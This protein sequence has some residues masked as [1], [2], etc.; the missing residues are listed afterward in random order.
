MSENALVVGKSDVQ[1][2]WMHE[3]MRMVRTRPILG[4]AN[5]LRTT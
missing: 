3:A 5:D 1:L 2:R 4:P